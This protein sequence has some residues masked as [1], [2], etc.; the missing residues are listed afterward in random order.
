VQEFAVLATLHSASA[1]GSQRGIQ[2]TEHPGEREG[3][4]AMI[5]TALMWVL[6][7]AV[8]QGDGNEKPKRFLVFDLI[9]SQ[10]RDIT[11]P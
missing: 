7:V 2:P 10:R 6:Q 4:A 5:G 11:L 9:H 3:S 1:R 8:P